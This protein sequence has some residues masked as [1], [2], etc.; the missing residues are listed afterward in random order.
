MVCDDVKRG[1]YSFLD[2]VLEAT[3]VSEFQ[4]HLNDCPGCDDRMRVQQKLRSF[5]KKR[6]TPSAAPDHL[7]GRISTALAKVRRGGPNVE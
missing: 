1:A 7:T 2:G 4:S 5:V 3:H 6:L